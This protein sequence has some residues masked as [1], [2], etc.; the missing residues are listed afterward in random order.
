MRGLRRGEPVSQYTRA[1]YDKYLRIIRSSALQIVR[2]G[3]LTF[4]E[5]KEVQPE[6]DEMSKVLGVSQ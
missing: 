1:E 4:A 3:E 5:W 6:L 2:E